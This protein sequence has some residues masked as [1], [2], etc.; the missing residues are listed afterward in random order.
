[1]NRDRVADVSRSG[2]DRRQALAGIGVVVAGLIA[3][4]RALADAPLPQNEPAGSQE[5]LKRTSIHQEVDLKASPQRI[6]AALLESKRFAAFS[7]LPAEIDP[8]EGG[9]FSMFGGLIGGRNVELI[10]G[11]RVVQAWRPSHWEAGRYSI[12]HFELKPK[13]AGTTVIFDHDG[14]PEG[15]YD[16]LLSGWNSHYWGPLEKYFAS[17]DAKAT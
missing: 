14:F 6:Y 12:A 16:S 11:Q 17:E 15:D 10:P 9:T 13:E 1:V 2:F 4:P 3:G 8:T 5:N 7:G